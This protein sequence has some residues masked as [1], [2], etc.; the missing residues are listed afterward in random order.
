VRAGESIHGNSC[1]FTSTPTPVLK[2]TIMLL[3]LLAAPVAAQSSAAPAMS[4]ARILWEDVANYLVQ[5]AVD[6]PAEKYA[7][8]PTPAVR[9]F[10]EIIGH[11]AGS[12]NM[13]CAMALGDQ[14]PAED[15]IEKTATTKEALV[16]ALKASNDYC[17]KAY[18]QPDASLDG[19]ME[20]FGQQRSRRFT[21]LMNATHDNEH[22]GNLVTYL[23]M[24][25]MVPPSSRPRARP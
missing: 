19:M 16:T 24:N 9:S 10:G 2:R 20:V 15:A 17:R 12:Q 5:S 6:M 18:S 11:V 21:L 8:K 13:F 25:G 3:A 7:F 14:P 1:S 22:Y 23:R 4:D